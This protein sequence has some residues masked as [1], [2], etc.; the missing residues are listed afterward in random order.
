[1]FEDNKR[2]N[3]QSRDDWLR[4][5]ADDWLPTLIGALVA[6]STSLIAIIILFFFHG[7]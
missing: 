6:M 1:M 3:I 4:N 2:N 5:K 7:M